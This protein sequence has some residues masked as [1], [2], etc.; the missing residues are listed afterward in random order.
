MQDNTPK[1]PDGFNYN[2]KD[3]VFGRYC[4]VEEHLYGVPNRMLLHKC[5]RV[6]GSNCYRDVPLEA[7]QPG[8]VW[9]P[10]GTNV[11]VVACCGLDEDRTYRVPMSK[12]HFLPRDGVD[13]ESICEKCRDGE[14]PKDCQYYGEPN[15]C[16]SPHYGE[17]PH[18][19][20][21]RELE[22]MKCK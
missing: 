12:I 13:W 9:H 19:A 22:E 7:S 14:E 6:L 3:P 15:G 5:I 20:E 17:H 4:L 16:N 1:I 21:N 11:V 18:L 10:E 8:N 2:L